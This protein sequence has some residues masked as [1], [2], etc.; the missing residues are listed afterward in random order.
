MLMSYPRCIIFE[1]PDTVNDGIYYD[2]D[3]VFLEIPVKKWQWF[4]IVFFRR[5]IWGKGKVKVKMTLISQL[6]SIHWT[7]CWSS[8][9]QVKEVW[10][11]KEQVN[12]KCNWSETQVTLECPRWNASARWVSRECPPRAGCRPKSHFYR[13]IPAIHSIAFHHIISLPTTLWT[14]LIAQIQYCHSLNVALHV[15]IRLWWQ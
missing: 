1:I 6:W 13:T 3:W 9:P 15:F 14:S 7:L 2:F 12:D 11:R 5:R 10:M 8:D 4:T